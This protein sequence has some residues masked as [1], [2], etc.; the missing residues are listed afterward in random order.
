MLVLNCNTR[1]FTLCDDD[2][3]LWEELLRVTI[4][5]VSLAGDSPDKVLEHI[6]MHFNEHSERY[7]CRI[8][9]RRINALT[10][11]DSVDIR[12]WS[13]LF[14]LISRCMTTAQY[15]EISYTRSTNFSV[16]CT[17]QSR[18]TDTPFSSHS[19]Y[20]RR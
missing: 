12:G 6:A 16:I 17:P 4:S 1:N 11:L 2:L 20:Y 7:A 9:Q 8:S 15:P 5:S 10:P 3:A 18:K 19:T 14:S 13:S